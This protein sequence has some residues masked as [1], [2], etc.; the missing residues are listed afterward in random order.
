ML[1]HEDHRR[2]DLLERAR[3]FHPGGDRS[4]IY[5]FLYQGTG[6]NELSFAVVH[7]SRIGGRSQRKPPGAIAPSLFFF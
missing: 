5:S 7:W 3:E 2:A 6:F 4:L 1:A